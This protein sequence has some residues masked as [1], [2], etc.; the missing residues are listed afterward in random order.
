L[1]LSCIPSPSVQGGPSNW[2]H[3]PGEREHHLNGLMRGDGR[4]KKGPIALNY[5]AAI[6]P[7]RKARLDGSKLGH[8][9]SMPDEKNLM[10]VPA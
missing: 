3:V 4:R 9:A 6:G 7:P 2:K 10:I 8:E 1:I 5:G